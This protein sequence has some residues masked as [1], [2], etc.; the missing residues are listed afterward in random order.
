MDDREIWCA[1]VNQLQL[2]LC[3][4]MAMIKDDVILPRWAWFTIHLYGS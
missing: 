4:S 1:Y 2:P 3:I